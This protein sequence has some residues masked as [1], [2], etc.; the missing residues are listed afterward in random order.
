MN[1]ILEDFENVDGFTIVLFAQLE[2][3]PKWFIGM[4]TDSEII[5]LILSFEDKLVKRFAKRVGVIDFGPVEE[6]L[7]PICCQTGTVLIRWA[8][9]LR[10]ESSLLILPWA[11][12]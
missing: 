8:L 6:P 10:V 12:D 3:V 7:N 4:L 9:K 2:A 5:Y 1:S 11:D